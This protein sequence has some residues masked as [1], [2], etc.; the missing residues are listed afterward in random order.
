MTSTRS[1]SRSR[2]PAAFEVEVKLLSGET[3]VT[4]DVNAADSLVQLR[5]KIDA[6]DPERDAFPHSVLMFGDRELDFCDTAGHLGLCQGSVLTLLRLPPRKL[7]TASED[8][9]ARIFELHTGKSL[10]ILGGH[11]SAVVSVSFSEDVT[12]A[13]TMTSARSIAMY[14]STTGVQL[15]RVLG[16]VQ[17][18]CLAA[19]GRRV[20]VM[21]SHSVVGLLDAQSGR[22]LT[23][24]VH[25]A[26]FVCTAV[27]SP[28]GKALLTSSVEGFA[29]LFDVET[30]GCTVTFG[31]PTGGRRVGMSAAA[32]SPDASKVLASLYDGS[33]D[34]YARTGERICTCAG[35]TAPLRSCIMSPDGK[36][37]LTASKDGASKLFCAD[38]GA[39]RC[40]FQAASDAALCSAKFS[41]DLSKVLTAG[42]DGT[43]RLFDARTGACLQEFPDHAAPVLSATLSID[44]TLVLTSS[45]DLEAKLFDAKT[46][47]C[48]RS[49][50]EENG[51][52]TC[53]QWAPG[54]RQL[55]LAFFSGRVA[56][57]DPL[58]NA[59]VQ[60]FPG[61][62]DCVHSMKL[63]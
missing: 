58:S 37:I 32:F 2:S 3:L 15:W 61:H 9:T 44:G 18:A 50:S 63:I 54:G 38:T 53:A 34:L 16:P 5:E 46:G 20:L 13:L 43:A 26:Y 11:C 19:D 28:D 1:R 39:C 10:S 29:R 4:I 49:F 24:L 45:S 41:P 17:D 60:E 47:K 27:F 62:R 6:L 33:A 25:H 8:G 12:R 52:V 48:L 56:V 42:Q 30:G 23:N 31:R 55:L 40:T 35:H 21:D 14:D 59:F 36:M 7:C 22:L 57:F 51:F